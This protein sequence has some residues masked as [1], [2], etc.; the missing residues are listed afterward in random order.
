MDNPPIGSFSAVPAGACIVL[1]G[2]TGYIGANVARV[3]IDRGYRVVCLVR[4]RGKRARGLP[5]AVLE[6]ALAGAELKFIDACDQEALAGLDLGDAAPAAV[7]SCLAS[8]GGGVRD[9]WAVEHR[10]NRNVLQLARRSGARQFIL[11][12]AI[13]VQKPRLAFQHAKLA[14]EHDLVQSGLAYSIVRPTAFFKSLAGQLQAVAAGK[15]FVLFGDGR[16]TAC[17]PISEADLACYIADCLTDPSRH[18]AI[19]PIGGPGEA[20]TP[21]QQGE[22]LFR[23][24]GR[25][26]RFRQVPLALFDVIIPVL[27]ALS[28]L[29]PALRDKAEFA[30]IGRYY[31]SESML[32]LNPRTGEYDPAATPSTGRDTL[33]AFYRG[34]LERGMTGQELGEHKLF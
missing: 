5:P 27:A 13:C 2:A 4:E 24:C 18:N 21:R 12:S 8:R 3:L 1:A 15:P 30:R 32:L 20:L 33:E 14:F 9:A 6:R 10:A 29:L 22:M 17:K 7:I 16:L 28:R 23:L 26:P 11:L 31:A 19:L 34:V 25:E